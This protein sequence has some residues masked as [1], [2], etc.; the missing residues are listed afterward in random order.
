MTAASITRRLERLALA[1]GT[2][3][4]TTCFG[5]P[6]RQIHEDPESGHVWYDSM[7]DDQCPACGRQIRSVLC[8]VIPDT[9][10]GGIV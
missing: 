1:L 10:T 8:I 3:R 5:H 6:V 7:P 2:R 9:G 4:C